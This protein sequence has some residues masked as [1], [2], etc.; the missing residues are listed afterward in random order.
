R[1]EAAGLKLAFAGGLNDHP[2]R[3][4]GDIVKIDWGRLYLAAPADPATVL[5]YQKAEIL[6][7]SFCRD[8]SIDGCDD[9]LDPMTTLLFNWPVC[10]ASHDFGR[11]GADPETL[12]LA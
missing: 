4:C 6:R 3:E 11:V 12:R 8:G 2:L 7:G 1:G 9:L 5:R 10:A